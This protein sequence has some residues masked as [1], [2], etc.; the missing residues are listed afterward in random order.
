MARPW[1]RCEPEGF[2]TSPVISRRGSMCPTGTVSVKQITSCRISLYTL[3]R[4]SCHSDKRPPSFVHPLRI[5]TPH[6][7]IE[8]RPM[9]RPN[10][11]R[12]PMPCAVLLPMTRGFEAT[13]AMRARLGSSAGPCLDSCSF[14]VIP[15]RPAVPLFL[16]TSKWLPP[17]R[18]LVRGRASR[19]HARNRV[20]PL[21]LPS[22]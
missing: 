15:I 19:R 10:R 17:R 11:T 22:G 7:G 12:T 8:I 4:C 6:E 18:G 9:R 5:A 21:D 2:C 14:V 1:L 13:R 16:S 20:Q 3:T